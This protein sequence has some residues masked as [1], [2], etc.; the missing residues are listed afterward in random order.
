MHESGGVQTLPQPPQLLGS[1]VVSVQR[2][3]QQVPEE[4]GLAAEQMGVPGEALQMP[5]TQFGVEPG[6]TNPLQVQLPL[7]HCS[8]L[9]VL[10]VFPQE[11]QLLLSFC[12]LLQMLLEP[13]HSLAPQLS[14]LPGL[15]QAQELTAQNP[16][17]QL[18]VAQS[19]EL[20]P[21]VH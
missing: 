1:A 2:L 11:P 5:L 12:K 3:E 20:P 14:W 17:Q 6:Q 18:P 9:L 21:Q 10:H 8:P 16:L 19:V 15:L 4:Q 7:I 13:Q